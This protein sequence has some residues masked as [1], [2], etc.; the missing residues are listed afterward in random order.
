MNSSNSTL[1]SSQKYVSAVQIIV[2][3]NLWYC[4]G[5]ILF[6]VSVLLVGRQSARYNSPQ[7]ASKMVSELEYSEYALWSQFNLIFHIRNI[8]SSYL[9]EQ[10]SWV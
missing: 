8:F 9:S 5:K 4:F 10:G 1:S 3:N 2:F 6:T 7:C